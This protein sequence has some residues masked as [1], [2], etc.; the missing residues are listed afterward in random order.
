MQ[1]VRARLEHGEF[2]RQVP[3]AYEALVDI[4]QAVEAT[5]FDRGLAELVKLR[6]SQINGCAFCLGFHLAQA[7][8]AGVPQRKLDL[9]ASWHDA[10]VFNSGERTALRWAEALTLMPHHPIPD[11]L[12]AETRSALGEARL[13]QLTVLVALANAWNRIGGAWRFTPPTA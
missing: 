1:D 6:V 3:G 12:H 13:A 8:R 9:V 5:G 4:D 2:F 10:P 7:R 11:A